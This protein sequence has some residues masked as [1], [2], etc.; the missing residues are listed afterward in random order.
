MRVVL[1]APRFAPDVG[2]VE[3]VVADTAAALVA[4]GVAVVVVTCAP[5]GRIANEHVA[6]EGGSYQVVRVL[7][8]RWLHPE[9]VGIGLWRAVRAASR[10]SD[11]VHVHSYHG[12]AALVGALARRR[13]PLV[14][15]L[16]YHGGGH[17]RLRSLLHA[18]YRPAGSWMVRTAAVVL[19]SSE[20]EAQLVRR[21]FPR[22]RS[23]RV[24]RPI[25]SVRTQQLL[26][27]AIEA[28]DGPVGARG[29]TVMLSVCRL[30]PYKRVDL[31]IDTARGHLPDIDLVIVGDGVDRER[32]EARARGADNIRFC[33]RITDTE[34]DQWWQ[35]SDLIVSASEDESYGLVVAQAVANRIRCVVSDIPAHRELVE[36]SGVGTLV[37]GDSAAVWA[38]SIRNTLCAPLAPTETSETPTFAAALLDI[39]DTARAQP[40][41]AS[42]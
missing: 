2:G 5:S 1:V 40:R 39:Y 6:C 26:P 24:A 16:Y 11:V 10:T 32:L 9:L 8:R 36:H 42:R 3:R 30:D 35:R 17:T 28:P 41:G 4:S 27:R 19:C 31:L 7:R 33:G 20:A 29:R 25:H 14:A 18:V 13:R 12:L 38:G 37:S 22:Q 23:I 34:L 15:S 21:D